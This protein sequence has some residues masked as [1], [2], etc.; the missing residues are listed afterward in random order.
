MTIGTFCV[1]VGYSMER[2]IYAVT[3]N[4]GEV[5]FLVCLQRMFPEIEGELEMQEDFFV[6]VIRTQSAAKRTS[7]EMG[8]E[9][10]TVS[11]QG[12]RSAADDKA[13]RPGEAGISR[14]PMRQQPTR[15]Q[16]VEVTASSRGLNSSNSR[17]VVDTQGIALDMMVSKS[18]GKQGGNKSVIGV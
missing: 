1:L 8:A 14:Q 15:Q 5:A 6:N 4:A 18:K 9:A 17:N 13:E 10:I 7:A 12:A 16:P 11:R 2:G 3:A